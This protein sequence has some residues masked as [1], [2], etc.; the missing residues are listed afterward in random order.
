MDKKTRDH[1]AMMQ[2]LNW[3]GIPTLFRCPYNTDTE[4]CDIALVGVPHST[5]NGTT[6]RDQHLGPRAV[7]NISALGR[8]AHLK[9][10]LVPWDICDIRDLGDVPLP[11]ANNN[12]K[13]IEHITDFYTRIA[14]TKTRP[15]SVGGDHSITGGILQAIASPN[16]NLTGG[17][18]AVLLHFDAHT[19]TFHQ[20]DHFLGAIKSAAHWASYLVRDGFVDASSSVQIGIRGN[21]RTLDWLDSSYELGYEV[22]TKQKYDEYGTKRCLEIIHERV[23]DK[24]LYITFDLDCLD[25]VFAPGVANLEPAIEGFSMKDV[26]GLLQGMRGKNI[27]GGDVVCLMPTKDSPNQITAHVANSILFEMVCLIADKFQNSPGKN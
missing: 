22:I 7:R 8:R 12:E 21:P 14:E 24:P 23:G 15:L 20:L 18:K 13:C 3:W 2:G 11:E 4:G 1:D 17:E 26:L 5:G 19:D 6:E 27:I 10:G 25:P 9:F 16:S